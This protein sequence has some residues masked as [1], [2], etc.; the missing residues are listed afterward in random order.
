MSKIKAIGEHKDYVDHNSLYNSDR[1]F[2]S[3]NWGFLSGQNGKHYLLHNPH[4]QK[5][6]IIWVMRM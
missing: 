5:R 1:N 6:T 4:C 2:R 3:V